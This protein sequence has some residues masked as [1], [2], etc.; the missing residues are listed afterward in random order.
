VPV[1][2]SLPMAEKWVAERWGGERWPRS[3]RRGGV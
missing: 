2:I 1:P 3:S